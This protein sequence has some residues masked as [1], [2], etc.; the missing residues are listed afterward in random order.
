M[1]PSAQRHCPNCGMPVA[2]RAETCLMC[3]AQLK[4]SRRRSLRLPQG[5]VLWPLLLVAALALL[6]LWKPWQAKEPQAMA[7]APATETPTATPVPSATYSV[8]PTATPLYS[9]TPPP[10]PTLP[11]NQTHHTVTS[12]ETVSSIAKKYGATIRGILRA[13]NLNENSILSVGQVLIIPLPVANTPTPTATLTPSPTPFLYT[14]KRGDTLSA[15][16]SRYKTTVEALMQANNITDATR[17]QVGTKIT[18]VQPP[19]YAATMAY[20]IYEVQPNDTLMAISAKYG[21]TVAEIQKINGLQGNRLSIGQKLQ[22]P[23]GTATPTPTLTPTAT[24]TPTPGPARP[25]PALLGP[26]DGTVFEGADTVILLNW[27]SIGIL[28]EDEWYVVRMRRSGVVAQ[29]L[30]LVWTKATSW[31]LP[32]DLYIEGLAE[33]QRFFWQVSIMQQTGVD[34]QGIWFGEQVSPSSGSRTFSW[35]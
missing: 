2:Q 13:N 28:N 8:A 27:V 14:I 35:K 20:E 15:I 1:E 3:G 24:L 4:E 7:P 26:P 18:I 19:D 9:P 10:T 30:P 33:P 17:I 22:I 29:Q 16:A 6:W 12:G 21:V 34:E 5:E 31:R 11:P 25:A 23:V 32:G